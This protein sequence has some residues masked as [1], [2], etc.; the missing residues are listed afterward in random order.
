MTSQAC[1]VPDSSA[2][3]M[4]DDL[5]RAAGG[6]GPRDVTIHCRCTVEQSLHCQ[7]RLHIEQVI[8]IVSSVARYR[9]KNEGRLAPRRGE[10]SSQ[11]DD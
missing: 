11:N 8:V 3:V 7:C 10:L 6:D 4:N 2:G 1:V 5:V 9:E